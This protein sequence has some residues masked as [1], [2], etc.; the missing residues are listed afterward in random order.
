MIGMM[1][2]Q[3]IES[4]VRCYIHIEGYNDLRS[5]YYVMRREYPGE[6]DRKTALQAIRNVLK[7]ETR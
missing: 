1:T 6:F 3:E 7:E 2:E 5:I 4:L